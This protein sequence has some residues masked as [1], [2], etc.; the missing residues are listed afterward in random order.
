MKE[1]PTEMCWQRWPATI[2][3]SSVVRGLKAKQIHLFQLPVSFSVC[4]SLSMP[5]LAFLQ[6]VRGMR[7]PSEML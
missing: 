5:L 2:W 3:P 4:L 1:K 6:S 7:L